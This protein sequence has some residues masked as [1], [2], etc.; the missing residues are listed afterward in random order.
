MLSAPGHARPAATV[1]DVL[2]LRP[3]GFAVVVAA[4]LVV[5]ACRDDT[6]D[7]GFRPD[8]GGTYSYEA[9]VTSDTVTDLS[10]QLPGTVRDRTVLDVHQR[11]LDVGDDG[12]RVEVVLRRAG[13]GDRVFVMRFD[14]A[15]QLTAVESVEGIPAE[16]LGQLGLS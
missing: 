3:V 13:I 6:V 2:C 15:A 10:G 12:V 7:L 11:V 1:A 16:A 4:L 14:R 5:P 9:R 8:A